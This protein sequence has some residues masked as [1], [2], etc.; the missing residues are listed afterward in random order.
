[1]P[2]PNSKRV[3]LNRSHHYFPPD[4]LAV[5]RAMQQLEIERPKNWYRQWH[6]L[7]NRLHD[8][9]DLYPWQVPCVV[10]PDTVVT[11]TDDRHRVWGPAQ[12]KQLYR[13]LAAAASA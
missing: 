9:L 4:A 7:N 13:A 10:H 12:Q 8:A 3:P 2:H 1:M 6:Q 5:F 11:D